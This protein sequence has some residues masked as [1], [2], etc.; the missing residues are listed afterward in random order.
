[1]LIDPKRGK[2]LLILNPEKIRDRAE[3]A[4]QDRNTRALSPGKVTTS[5]AEGGRGT[6]EGKQRVAAPGCRY[7]PS[8]H[9][10]RESR[11]GLGKNSEM[12]MPTPCHSQ[13]TW[14]CRQRRGFPILW[15]CRELVSCLGR[16]TVRDSQVPPIW[17][18][19]FGSRGLREWHLARVLRRWVTHQRP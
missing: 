15:G 3:R 7:D 8:I 4:C 17:G 10:G 5:P 18:S 2:S 13:S 6:K 11:E 16:P 1:M 19:L 12:A 14:L 9:P